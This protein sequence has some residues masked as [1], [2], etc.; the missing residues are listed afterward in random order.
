MLI[1]IHD[2]T[3]VYYAFSCI[4][5]LHN[6]TVSIMHLQTYFVFIYSVFMYNMTLCIRRT[7]EKILCYLLCTAPTVAVRNA[8]MNWINDNSAVHVSWTPLTLHE[9]RG[10]PLYVVTY[11]PT[12]LGRVSCD[13]NRVTTPNSSVV[14][15]GLDPTTLYGFMVDVYTGNGTMK[16]NA[17][18]GNCSSQ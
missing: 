4:G 14:I 3:R 8:V 2:H 1:I 13:T 5:L 15:G 18:A 9:A 17:T 7:E 6:F 11:Y 16:G 10:F 12:S